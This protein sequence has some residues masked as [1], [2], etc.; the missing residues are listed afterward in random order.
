MNIYYMFLFLVFMIT[1]TIADTNITKFQAYTYLDQGH[2]IISNQVVESFDNV[3]IILS[4]TDYEAE[5]NTTLNEANI[6][7][8][9][10][11]F[12][13][14]N[15]YTQET[16]NTY[17]SVRLKSNF[18]SKGTTKKYDYA[19]RARLPLSRSKK[20]YN[21]FINDLTEDNKDK[22]INN[23]SGTEI[24]L[25][26]FTPAYF[27]IESKYSVGANGIHPFARARYSMLKDYYDWRIE[28]TQQF[29]YKVGDGFTEETNIYFSK[30]E[31]DTS[32]YRV[33]LSRA[34]GS[35]KIGMDYALG[36]QHYWTLS[37][38]KG[39]LL[40]Q[41][42]S[43][44]TKYQYNGVRDSG[45]T[46]YATSLNFRRSVFRKWFFYEIS[47]SVSF[48]KQYDYKANYGIILLI[49]FYFGNFSSL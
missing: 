42:F 44:N 6:K 13:N 7:K 35:E 14:N 40:S 21:L 31:T 29:K 28:P 8:D 30:Q 43:G 49:D 27:G 24:G 32:L 20:K 39:L 45:I 47:P 16:K 3:D 34:S 4:G 46:N 18:Y 26:V 15:K 22:I 12:F 9:V 17:I 10:D 38:K 37:D 19:V 11:R 41:T 5:Q 1:N 25:S 33:I 23:E 2:E 48:S 36:L